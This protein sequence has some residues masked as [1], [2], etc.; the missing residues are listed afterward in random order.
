M[1]VNLLLQNKMRIF[2][3]IRISLVLFFVVVGHRCA[4]ANLDDL[5]GQYRQAL[6]D[7]K[8][9]EIKEAWMALSENETAV[10]YI[11]VNDSDLYEQFEQGYKNNIKMIGKVQSSSY[12]VG[13]QARDFPIQ[14][15]RTNAQ[16]VQDE[17]LNGV[18]SNNDLADAF[19]NQN[20]LSNNEVIESRREQME[21]AGREYDG[22]GLILGISGVSQRQ[23]KSILRVLKRQFKVIKDIEQIDFQRG[24]VEYRIDITGNAEDFANRLDDYRFGAFEF[25]L[26]RFQPRRIDLILKPI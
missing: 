7:G 13:Q 23:Q 15:R 25:D 17:P 10:N 1:N 12:D 16:I 19:G 20:R 8:R 11:K 6:S 18:V 26:I 4:E 2:T 9:T 14:D 21:R 22:E 5:I 3:F 24:L